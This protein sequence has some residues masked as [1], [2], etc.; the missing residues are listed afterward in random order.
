MY[1]QNMPEDFVRA[2]QASVQA[3]ARHE[4]IAPNSAPAPATTAVPLFYERQSFPASHGRS[5]EESS[6]ASTIRS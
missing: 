5:S 6:F 2:G 3:E 4:V 1:S